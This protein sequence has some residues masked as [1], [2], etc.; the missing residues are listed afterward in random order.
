ETGVELSA[1]GAT[2]A[3]VAELQG[4]VDAGKLNDKLARTVLE[5]VVAG[6][7]DPAAVIA[8]RGLGVVSDTGALTAA[9]DE[10]IAAN[11]EIAAKVRDGKVAAA[12]GPVGGGEKK[13]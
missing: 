8:A 7:G 11:P 3:Q 13:H 2:P 10:A 9:V 5:G 6:E 12:G 4:L 1:V